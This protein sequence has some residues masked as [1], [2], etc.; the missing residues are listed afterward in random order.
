MMQ[1]GGDEGGEGGC[2]GGE[3]GEGGMAPPPQAQHMVLEVKSV[4]S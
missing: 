3:G 4:S 1:L 2:E